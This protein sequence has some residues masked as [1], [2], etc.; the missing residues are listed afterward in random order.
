MSDD[1]IERAKAH[2]FAGNAHFEAGRLDAARADYE[3]ALALVPGRPSVLANLGVT[4]C[5]LGQWNAAVQQ[6]DA[7]L[8]ADPTHRDAWAALGLS[9]EALGQW[10][11]AAHALRQAIALGA[12]QSGLYL[13]LAQCELRQDRARE[14]LQ[15]LDDALAADD[16]VAEVW[17][18]RGHLLRENGQLPEAAR[19]YERALQ[20]GADADLH[21]YYLAAVTDVRE[22]PAPPPVYA[23]VLFDQYADEFQD[24]LLA[25][26]KYAAPDTLLKPLL[27]NDRRFGLVLDLGCGTGLCGRRVAPHA[28]AVEGVDASRVMVDR[29]RASGAYREVV[30]GDL[31]GFLRASREPADLILSA[32]VFIYVGPLDEVF[33]AAAQ[34]LAPGGVFAFSVEQADPGRDLQ[35]RPSL[36]YAH[37]RELVQRLAFAHGFTVQAIEAGPIREEQR[38]PVMGWY[39]WLRREAVAGS[40]H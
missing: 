14:A 27:A 5:R 25:Q 28:D 22:P 17:S 7:A 1:T 33:A 6:L 31:L 29:A 16:T 36:R 10:A 32:D 15:A 18:Q 4:L 26:L 8:L 9:R 40:V 20:H 13:S 2:F 19:S 34:R 21:R 38:Q 11:G 23:S 3:A 24:H 37:S 30:H 35:L 12:Q 39:V